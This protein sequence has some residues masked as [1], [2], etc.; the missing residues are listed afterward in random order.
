MP[1]PCLLRRVLP[2]PPFR[3]AALAFLTLSAFFATG[4]HKHIA[5][6][7]MEHR[8]HTMQVPREHPTEMHYLEYLPR[9]Y[10]EDTNRHWPLVIY[11]HGIG[12]SGT[13]LEKVLRF[14]PPKIIAEGKDLPCIIISPQVPRGYFWFRESNWTLE[15]LEK[16]MRERRVDRDRVHA[17]GNSMGAFGAV[18]LVAREPQLF[19]SCVSVCGGVD[20]MDSLRLR[21]VPLRAYHGA[22]DPIIP[23]EES[24]RMVEM[25]NRIGGQAELIL[26]PDLGHN[27]WD[28]A[29]DDPNLWQ[30]ML[31]QKKK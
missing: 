6:I 24:R 10:H 22:K 3:A 9:G 7:I 8:V 11:L 29:Y 13:D 30:W 20:F 12:E 21:D 14:G 31:A 19:A 4:C 16:V 1:N 23:V 28:R 27:C 26:Y 17:T 18:L 2:R 5:T 15:I 25:V